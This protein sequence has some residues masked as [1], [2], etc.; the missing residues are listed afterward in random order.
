[1]SRV[2]IANET[3]GGV[4]RGN[5]NLNFIELF[6]HKPEKFCGFFDNA[7]DIQLY[8]NSEGFTA[9]DNFY[10][11]ETEN[12]GQYKFDKD[13][14]SVHDGENVIQ[15]TNIEGSDPGRWL[16]ISIGELPS[17][18]PAESITETSAKQFV[19]AAEKAKYNGYEEQ[20]QSS[21]GSLFLTIAEIKALNSIP[22]ELNVVNISN[23]NLYKFHKDSTSEPDDL[24][25]IKTT[26]DIIEGR[27]HAIAT[28]LI[29]IQGTPK[30]ANTPVSINGMKMFDS[31]YE[32]IS[33]GD[34]EW[35]KISI[36]K[37]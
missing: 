27:F 13:S 33:A 8:E 31:E 22:D 12:Q 11:I 18:I 15:P 10:A 23:G 9:I 17:S 37:F 7:G 2:N 19:S 16:L 21:K 35:H 20:I 36:T 30:D 26:E 32:Y 24:N 29:S 14:V 6:K 4:I 28:G 25:I 34:N 3:N 5:I 1:M